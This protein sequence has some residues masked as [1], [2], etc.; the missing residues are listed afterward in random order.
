MNLFKKIFP[1]FFTKIENNCEWHQWSDKPQIEV[2]TYSMGAPFF[3]GMPMPTYVWT[4]KK[5][6]K[7]TILNPRKH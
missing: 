2:I 5:C 1:V 7:K 4:C 3:G 6:G